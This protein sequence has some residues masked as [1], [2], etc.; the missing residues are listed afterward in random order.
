MDRRR[1]KMETSLETFVKRQSVPVDALNVSLK[2]ILIPLCPEHEKRRSSSSR[3]PTAAVKRRSTSPERTPKPK[4]HR[5]RLQIPTEPAALPRANPS[6]AVINQLVEGTGGKSSLRGSQTAANH[7]RRTRK[8]LSAS[9]LP[10]IHRHTPPVSYFD[11][12]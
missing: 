5:L 8:P 9:Y 1:K 10:R 6:P 2:E 7:L 4:R 3:G 12:G 11:R